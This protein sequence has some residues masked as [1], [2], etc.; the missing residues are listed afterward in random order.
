MPS[1]TSC[2]YWVFR[3]GRSTVAGRTVLRELASSLTHLRQG[4]AG[5]IA[6]ALIRAGE[7]ETALADAGSRDSHAAAGITNAVAAL[8]VGVWTPD[9]A[10]DCLA[11]V[12]AQLQVPEQM[13]I[14]TA[15][16]FA[17]YALH[18]LAFADLVDALELRSPRTAVIG[19]RSIGA[20]LSAVV[21][22]TL[23][24]RNVRAERITVRPEGHPYDRRTHF[25]DSQLRWIAAHRSHDA[26][27]LIVDEGPGLSGSSFLSVGEALLQAGVERRRIRFLCSR[28][29]H[30]DGL[31]APGA[32]QRWRAFEALWPGNS[33]HMPEA[34]ELYIGGGEWRNWKCRNQVEWP[35]SWISMERAKYLSR[36]RQRLFKFTGLGH[37][38]SAVEDR[39]RILARS[40]FGPDRFGSSNGYGEYAVIDGAPARPSML[41]RA[42]L[43]RIADYC[44]MRASEFRDSISIANNLAEVT[45]FNYSVEFGEEPKGF[46]LEARNIVVC[47]GRMLPHEWIVD[48]EGTLRKTDGDTHGDDHFFPGPADIAWDVA[49]AIVEWGMDRDAQEYFVARFTTATGDLVRHRIDA[50]VLAYTLFR[51]GMSLMGAHG[52]SGTD[53]EKRLRTAATSYRRVLRSFHAVES[54]K[55][56]LP[57]PFPNPAPAA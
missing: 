47:D 54:A 12:A 28:Q 51:I 48:R 11:D 34:A 49:G 56:L 1:K 41:S 45:R 44:S 21:T 33:R 8:L 22:A 39:A 6:E 23:A 4:D 31:V 40:G 19:I 35:A 57:L 25:N 32:A 13:Q 42:V 29:P 46:E 26:D 30:A 37:F 9:S 7:L 20:T 43:D 24:R 27:F 52:L 50:Y 14:S 18:P 5:R 16:G 53:E 36:D 55:D 38:G 10:F 2:N 3:E 15:E 17:Y